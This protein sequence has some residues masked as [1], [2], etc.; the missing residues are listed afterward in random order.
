[1]FDFEEVI[2]RILIVIG[3]IVAILALIV[4]CWLVGGGIFNL[5][6]IRGLNC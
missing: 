2:T 5:W 3:V 1:M 6:P 4:V